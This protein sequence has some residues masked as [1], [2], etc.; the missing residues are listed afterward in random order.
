M[1]VLNVVR[2]L[3]VAS[4]TMSITRKVEFASQ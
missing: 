2:D 3:L 4:L 1:L